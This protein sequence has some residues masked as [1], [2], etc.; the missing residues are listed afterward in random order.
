MWVC[1]C[2]G[3]IIIIGQMAG[4]CVVCC[5]IDLLCT[6][7]PHTQLTYLK[8]H[9]TH[10]VVVQLWGPPCGTT[11]SG[12]KGAAEGGRPSS[13]SPPSLS[14]DG[15]GGGSTRIASKGGLWPSRGGIC[16]IRHWI[17]GS[18]AERAAKLFFCGVCE[19]GV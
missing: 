6:H 19:C 15:G 9:Q 8:K 2:F 7:N 3:V 16:R 11:I 5:V 1:V 18:R 4:W 17:W 10:A 12:G 13:F 14:A